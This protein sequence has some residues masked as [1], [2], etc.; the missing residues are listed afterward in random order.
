[1]KPNLNP[2]DFCGRKKKVDGKWWVSEP[3]NGKCKW[4]RL[5]K[6]EKFHKTLYSRA[7]AYIKKKKLRNFTVSL[8]GV[9]CTVYKNLKISSVMKYDKE[10][11]CADFLRIRKVK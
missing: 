11:A 6:G 2:E 10:W 5:R 1:M 3:I 9:T 4:R 8:S 7:W